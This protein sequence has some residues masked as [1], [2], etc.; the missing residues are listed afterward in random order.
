MSESAVSSPDGV[1][2]LE[3]SIYPEKVESFS[4]SSNPIMSFTDDRQIHIIP[5]DAHLQQ[6]VENERPISESS[7]LSTESTDAH[8]ISTHSVQAVKIRIL[9]VKT[10]LHA[11]LDLFI[12]ALT[13]F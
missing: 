5:A 1:G 3:G 9:S 7:V 4:P 8:F 2:I 6:G 12:D 11:S 13:S 10:G